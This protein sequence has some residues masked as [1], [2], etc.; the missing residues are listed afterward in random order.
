MPTEHELVPSMRDLLEFNA[1][2]V[3]DSRWEYDIGE[4]LKAIDG[5]AGPS[6]EH[7]RRR[8]RDSPSN[9]LAD[10]SGAPTTVIRSSRLCRRTSPP[11]ISGFG[12]PP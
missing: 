7:S 11:T 12:G 6:P 8:R 5:V 10:P 4:L 1:A 2:E 9:T 3:T